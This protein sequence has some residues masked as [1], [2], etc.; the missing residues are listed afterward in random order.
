MKKFFITIVILGAI[1]YGIYYFGTN[2][3]S[4]QLLDS[5]STEL[6]NSGQINDLKTYIESD[7]ELS[8]MVKEAESADESTLPFTSKG[9]A[10]RVLI[11]KV[12]ITKLQEIQSQV[13]NGTASKGEVL[14]VLNEKLTDEE[15]LA[16]QVIA[17]KEIYKK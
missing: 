13:Q 12:G 3:A 5:A 9:E 17:Y 6:E 2:V 16:L 1:G 15:M 11:K 4:D 14:Q 10:T 7:P 8:M